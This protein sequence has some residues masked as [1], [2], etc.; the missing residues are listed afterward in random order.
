ME[1][2]E[3]KNIIPEQ[4]ES[5]SAKKLRMLGDDM[6]ESIHLESDKAV[7][8]KLWEN[9]WYRHKWAIILG[10]IALI[11]LLILCLTMCRTEKKDINIMYVG[12]EYNVSNVENI[13]AMEE[14]LALICPDYDENGEVEVSIPSL[15]YKSPDQLDKYKEENPDFDMSAMLSANNEALETFSAQIMSGELTVYLIDPYLYELQAK[16]A[17]VPISEILG[18]E[19][20]SELL[21]DEKAV[22]FSKTDFAQHYSEFDIL[23]EDTLICVVKTVAT[24]DELLQNSCDF[25]KKIIEFEPAQ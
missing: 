18:Y 15:I 19:A 1:N 12:P 21:Y 7:K 8:G 6:N 25:V 22:Y 13:D 24:D 11:M 16:Q 23:P 2:N 3:N 14:K 17:C 10:G 9:I 20:D 5:N 4:N